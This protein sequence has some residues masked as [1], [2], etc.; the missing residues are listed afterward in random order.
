SLKSRYARRFPHAT[1][2]DCP[3]FPLLGIRRHG[4]HRIFAVEFQFD[5]AGHRSY[6]CDSW[7][8]RPSC[9]DSDAA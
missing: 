4:H 7:D 8:K 2:I 5:G 3:P 1:T 9:V 6:T